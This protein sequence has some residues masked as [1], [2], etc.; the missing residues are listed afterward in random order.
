MVRL[1]R[2]Y[3]HSA[4]LV[5]WE[6]SVCIGRTPLMAN[7]HN[8]I[9]EAFIWKTRHQKSHVLQIAFDCNSH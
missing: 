6:S 4:Y 9:V 2:T 1:V 5:L 7:N 3:N 8:M